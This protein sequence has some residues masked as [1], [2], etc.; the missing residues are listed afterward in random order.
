MTL[1]PFGPYSDVD[2][3]VAKNRDKTNPQAYCGALEQR[4]KESN[5]DAEVFVDE[6]GDGLDDVTGEPVEMPEM[7]ED[8]PEP[9]I[10]ADGEQE[11]EDFHSLLVVEGVWTGDGR[12]IEEGALTWRNL[13]L[14]LMATDRTTEGHMDA[15]LIGN[16]TRIEREGREIHGWG[17]FV[18]SDDAT[19]MRLQDF[20]R[21]GDLRG[22]SVDLDAVEYDIVLPAMPDMDEVEDVVEDIEDEMSERRFSSDDAK[23]KVTSARIMGATV[24]PFPAFEEA[25]I[26]SLAALVASLATQPVATG[27]VRVMANYSDIDF[28]PPLGARQEAERGLAWREE[29]GRGGTAVGVARARDIKNGVNLSP[30]TVNRMSSYFARHRSE[31]RR[32]G[33][34]CR[35]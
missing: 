24:V 29:F 14:P 31:E 12:W 25:Y 34:E 22:V 3:C 2:D 13:P 27:Y 11:G 4:L 26:E 19:I 18:Q 1:M 5:V 6:D 33:K 30:T 28:T 15:V 10:E 32:V 7:V 16:I 23:M 9:M 17:R 20:I 35:L 8:A 21:N